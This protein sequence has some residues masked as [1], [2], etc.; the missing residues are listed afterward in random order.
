MGIHP[1]IDLIL[2]NRELSKLKSTYVDALPSSMNPVTH[3]IHTSFNQTGTVTGRLASAAPNLQNIP[4][5]TEIGRQVRTAFVAD[6]GKDLLSVDYSQ[7][8]LRIVAHMAQ[9][10]GC[11]RFPCKPGYP[12]PTAAAIIIAISRG[13]KGNATACKS[14]QFPDYF[15]G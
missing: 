1:V 9:D 10:E 3:R 2:E 5:R 14:H 11:W 13:H 15:M 8:E 4:T 6:Q 7:I 12:C